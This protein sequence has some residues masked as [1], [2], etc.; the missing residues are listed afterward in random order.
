[1]TKVIVAPNKIEQKDIPSLPTPRGEV[2]FRAYKLKYAG[3]VQLRVYTSGK[4][5][6]VSRIVDEEGKRRVVTLGH[7]P[8]MTIDSALAKY[9][10]LK[11]LGYNT[12]M[13]HLEAEAIKNNA[14]IE[15]QIKA[16]QAKLAFTVE[17]LAPEYLKRLSPSLKAPENI[18][19]IIN[20]HVTELLAGK[21]L[22]KLDA[23]WFEDAFK[24][25]REKKGDNTARSTFIYCRKFLDYC[26]SRKGMPQHAMASLDIK[27][28]DLK[29]KRRKRVLTPIETGQLLRLLDAHKGLSLEVKAGLELLLLTAVRSGELIKAEWR[30]VDLAEGVWHVPAINSKNGQEFNVMLAPRAIELLEQLK[31]KHPKGLVMG[32]LAKATM[33]RAFKRLQYPNGKGVVLL[34]YEYNYADDEKKKHVVC[35]DLRRT[36]RTFLSELGV[37]VDIAERYINHSR[38]KIIDIYDQSTLDKERLEAAVL[39]ADKLEA[40]RHG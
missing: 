13:A 2:K 30:H 3:G 14:Q 29:E 12:G 40:L 15:D 4:K 8:L 36:A 7:P 37:S 11:T 18:K 38:A 10:I 16:E 26:T 35:H 25:L 31:Q 22:D 5:A 28:L 24:A 39:L 23:E 1:M 19:R 21:E 20:L 32:G 33:N 34:P 27:D 17:R 6:F 9:Q